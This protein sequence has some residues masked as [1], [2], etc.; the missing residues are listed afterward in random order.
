MARNGVVAVIP[1]YRKYPQV[2]LDGFMHD[3]ADAVA[4]S[5]VHAADFGDDPDTLFVMAAS[6]FEAT[7]LLAGR[8]VGQ[9]GAVAFD[10]V[11]FVIERVIE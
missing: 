10:V 2:R 5:H 8:L 9:L 1:D 3:A 11:G 4:W 7:P 6:V